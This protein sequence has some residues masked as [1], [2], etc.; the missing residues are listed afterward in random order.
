MFSHC[1]TGATFN[2][3]ALYHNPVVMENLAMFVFTSNHPNSMN[4]TASD[5]RFV[6]FHCSNVHKGD[7]DYFERLHAYYAEPKHVRG[8][9]EFLLAVPTLTP[10]SRYQTERPITEYYREMQLANIPIGARYLSALVNAR[11]NDRMTTPQMF[12]QCRELA[13]AIN[14]PFHL[15]LNKFNNEVLPIIKRQGVEKLIYA[16]HGKD[17]Y[18]INSDLLKAQL[19]AV[20]KYDPDSFLP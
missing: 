4:I 3:R 10:I 6:L 20:K 14:I 16:S 2:Y 11:F 5:R 18:V 12:A 15:T 7:V 1:V 19:E 9:Y 13:E 17:Y 8:L